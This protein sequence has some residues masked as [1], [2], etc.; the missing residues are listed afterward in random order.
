MIPPADLLPSLHFSF[1]IFAFFDITILFDIWLF[2]D[3]FDDDDAAA[4]FDAHASTIF[5]SSSFSPIFAI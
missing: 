3:F 2:Y 5:L 1:F 4:F